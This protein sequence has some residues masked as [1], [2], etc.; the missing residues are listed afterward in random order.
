M[1][2]KH[3]VPAAILL[4]S[5]LAVAQDAPL[6]NIKIN[7]WGFYRNETRNNSD[8]KAGTKDK[9]NFAQTRLNVTMT[10]DLA[11][12]YGYV[13]FAPQFSKI[14]GQNET[15]PE[16]NETQSSGQL[17]DP[18]LN[19]HEAYIALRPTQNENFH[20]LAG[21]QEFAYGDHLLVGSVPWHRIGRSFDAVRARYKF[22][23]RFTLDA[24]TSKLQE[25]N[26]SQTGVTPADATAQGS[27]LATASQDSDFHGAYFSANLGAYAQA[28]DLYVFNKDNQAQS[29]TAPALQATGAFKDT[30]AYGARVKS[31]AGDTAVDYRAEVTLESVRFHGETDRTSAQQYDVEVGYTLPFK[32][33][34][35]A[36]EYFDASKNYDQLFPT[37]HKWLGYADIF[38]RRNIKGTVVHGSTKLTDKLGFF[39]DYHMFQ[40]SSTGKGWF[41]F[42]GVE[43]D[44]ASSNKKD[45]GNELDLIASYEFTKTVQFSVGYSW[46]NAGK[47]HKDISDANNGQ[48][49]WSFAQL[50]VRF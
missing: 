36:V 33:T 27:T 35:F 2:M 31:K 41:A 23:D 7:G 29:G 44:V 26:A 4:S 25:N 40:R 11:D 18:N 43:T 20:L 17:Y 49:Q 5:G 9:Q 13:V 21:R 50:L 30:L 34:R 48:T 39:A 16:G 1:K 45:L 32:S 47:F 46:V 8:F 22:S 37:A 15:T 10:G 19:L 42:N 6:K 28:V 38:A 24:F 12:N 14:S 3:V